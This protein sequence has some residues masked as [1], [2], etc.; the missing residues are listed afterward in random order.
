MQN[1]FDMYRTQETK[2]QT[3]KRVAGPRC[4]PLKPLKVGLF[5][6]AAVKNA[7]GLVQ[8]LWKAGFSFDERKDKFIAR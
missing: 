8:A 1:D 4:E 3:A 7:T 6:A 2:L 5:I